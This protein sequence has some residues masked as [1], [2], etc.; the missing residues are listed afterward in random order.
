MRQVA[1]GFALAC[2]AC[3]SS[4]GVTYKGASP[5]PLNLTLQC[6]AATA[7]TLGYKPTLTNH[8][9]TVEAIHKDSVLAPNEDGRQEVITVTGA[10]SKKNDGS[11]SITVKGATF[12]LHWTRI[13]LESKE[14]PASARV[15]EDAKKVQ[16]RC[17]SATG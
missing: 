10:D 8:G 15:V 11:S 3:G 12:T 9:N 16:V 4:M 6:A 2:A 14:I 17:G 13:G 5:Q 1:I 7:D